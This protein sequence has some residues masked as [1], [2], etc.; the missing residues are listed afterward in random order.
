MRKLPLSLAIAAA[1]AVVAAFVLGLSGIP[2][3]ALVSG[4]L[5][6]WLLVLASLSWDMP[7]GLVLAPLAAMGVSIWLVVEH[8]GAKAGQVSIC[9]V[10][11]VFNCDKVNT[12]EYSLIH[13]V[14]VALFGFAFYAATAAVALAGRMRRPD[15]AQHLRILRIAG[16]WSI[17]FS[18][19]MAWASTRVGAWC[20]FCMSLYGLNIILLAGAWVA[21][22]RDTRQNPDKARPSWLSLLVFGGGDRSV[23]W[24]VIV[25]VVALVAGGVVFQMLEPAEGSTRGTGGDGLGQLTDAYHQVNGTIELDG[26]EP[27]YGDPNAPF[28]LVEWADFACPYCGVAAGEIKDL[29]RRDPSIQLRFKHYPISGNCNRFVKGA[30]HATACEAAAST[31]CAGK[32]GRFWEMSSLLFKNQEY[33]ASSDIRFIAKQIGLDLPQFETCMADPTIMDGVKADIEAAG[34]ANI[35]GTPSMFMKGLYGMGFVQV[36]PKAESI[37]ALVSAVKSGMKLPP[38]KPEKEEE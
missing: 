36:T 14:P 9:N 24:A 29:I 15:C 20:L 38:P 28:M 7:T 27:V 10:N 30:R 23:L 13:G 19:Y 1:L 2:A 12:S 17:L 16:V 21:L 11:E 18:A 5:A 8:L 4:I 34:K 33:Q 32:Q 26:S 3:G 31:E 22:A 25:G 35:H 6:G 37:E